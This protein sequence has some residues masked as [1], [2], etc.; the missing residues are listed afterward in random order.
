LA[1][2]EERIFSQALR[3]GA[4]RKDDIY[5][6]ENAVDNQPAAERA[7][8]GGFFIW[9]NSCFGK[10]MNFRCFERLE[11]DTAAVPQQMERVYENGPMFLPSRD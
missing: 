10:W 2:P 7:S 6:S 11:A 3:F 8:P 5:E 4:W 1:A 9:H